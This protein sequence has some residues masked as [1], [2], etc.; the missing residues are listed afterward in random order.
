MEVKVTKCENGHY[1]D[2]NKYDTCPHCGAGEFV[3]KEPQKKK[4]GFFKKDSAKLP[5][6]KSEPIQVSKE[7]V[8][9]AEDLICEDV[10]TVGA[11]SSE[12]VQTEDVET[13]GVFTTTTTT[14]RNVEVPAEESPS[15]ESSDL[16]TGFFA[17]STD[18]KKPEVAPVAESSSVP[19]DCDVKTTGFFSI[20]SA[21]EKKT[22][23]LLDP[24]WI[25]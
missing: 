14:K 17:P 24:C 23:S 3:A 11:Y 16:T 10:E 2:M 21:P 4:F 25:R 13:Q 19:S 7:F 12:Q 22:G 20:G 15:F 18:E 5:E 6:K 9:P 1:Y 8:K